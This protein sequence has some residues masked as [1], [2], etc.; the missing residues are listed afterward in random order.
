V[1]KSR[2]T[3]GFS[4][5]RTA[6]GEVRARGDIDVLTAPELKAALLEEAS[7]T[8]RPLAL[9]ISDVPFIDSSGLS[10]L[11]QVIKGLHRDLVLLHPSRGVERM[12]RITGADRFPGLRIL[13]SEAA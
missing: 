5:R 6:P 2:H 8:D 4:V 13:F 9:D 7:L 1:R 11:F 10:V 3:P 12:L